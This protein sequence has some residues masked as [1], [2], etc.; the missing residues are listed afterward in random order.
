MRQPR[1][2]HGGVAHVVAP[3]ASWSGCALNL[4]AGGA[5]ISGGPELEVGRRITVS[6]DLGDGQPAISAHARVVWSR[7]EAEHAGVGVRFMRIDGEAAQRIEEL[8]AAH[9]RTVSREVVHGA[10]RVQLPGL[11]GR[12]RAQAREIAP[13]MMV[14]E[15]ELSWLPI[16]ATIVTETEPGNLREGRLTWVGVEVAP[17]GHARLCLHV[18]LSAAELIAETEEDTAGTGSSP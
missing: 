7:R 6:I 2:A 10:V 17:S 1:I 12:L 8:L 18:D 9:M 15:A 11:P 3:G 5:F 16:G 13:G 14:V 4:S